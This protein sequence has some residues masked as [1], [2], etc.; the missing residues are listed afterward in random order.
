M[1][2][3]KWAVPAAG[4]I[5]MRQGKR[6]SSEREL[7]ILEMRV[8]EGWAH[9]IIIIMKVAT[10]YQII[11]KQLLYHL[12]L[13]KPNKDFKILHPKI[14]Q[15]R[16]SRQVLC[17]KWHLNKWQNCVVNSN[18]RTKPLCSH[19]HLLFSMPCCLSFNYLGICFPEDFRVGLPWGWTQKKNIFD[20]I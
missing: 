1:W 13:M 5:L 10:M 2:S 14:G 7:W 12:M 19:P 9:F 20:H 18:F 16:L 3:Q 6:S 8:E 11:H 17:P 15:P 4:G